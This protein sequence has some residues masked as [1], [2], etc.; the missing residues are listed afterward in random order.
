DVKTTFHSRFDA[1]GKA[2]RYD[3]LTGRVL[4]PTE[5]LYALHVPGPLDID[6]I[7]ACLHHLAGSHDF[8]SFEASGSREPGRLNGRGAVRTIYRADFFPCS[9]R[10]DA[11]SFRFTGDGFLRHMVRNFVGTLIEAG[12]GKMTPEEFLAILQGR[13]RCLAG[14]TAPARALF[15]EQVFYPEGTL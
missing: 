12:A 1:T 2:Y 6:R 11:W 7:H 4:M 3:I 9:G 8:S 10:D 13:N 14:P 5:R 15:L